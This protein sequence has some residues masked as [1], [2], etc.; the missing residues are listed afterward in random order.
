MKLPLPLAKALE[1]GFNLLVDLD[2]DNKNRLADIQGQVIKLQLD[3][4]DLNIFLFIHADSIEVMSEFDGEI[5]T[6]IAGKPAAMLAMR[7]SNKGLFS[8]DVEISGNV[9]TG[10]KFKRYLDQLD[11]DWEEQLSHIVGDSVAFQIGSLFRNLTDYAKK[12]HHTLQ[13]NLG[14][15]L[16][17]EA[18]YLTPRSEANHFAED[19]DCLREA[20]DRLVA[21]VNALEKR[22][23]QKV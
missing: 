13:Q 1:T 2:P 5:D 22:Q 4:L 23:D 18:E 10:K 6:I 12:S 7:T 17:E 19:V 21:R 8:G 16:T 9:E 15:Y 14:E 20:Y 11:I 3:G